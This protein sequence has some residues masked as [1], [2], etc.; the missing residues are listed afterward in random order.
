MRSR[1][2]RGMGYVRCSKV[3]PAHQQ[4][5]VDYIILLPEALISQI[6]T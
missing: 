5:Y 1:R 4:S 3:E 6:G 2:V